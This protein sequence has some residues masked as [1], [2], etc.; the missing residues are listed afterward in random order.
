MR[1]SEPKKPKGMKVWPMVVMIVFMMMVAELM[2]RLPGEDVPE[3]G[4]GAGSS[5]DSSSTVEREPESLLVSESEPIEDDLVVDDVPRFTLEGPY[6]TLPALQGSLFAIGGDPDSLI[7]RTEQ[8]FAL[9]NWRS[10]VVIREIERPAGNANVYTDDKGQITA[11]YGWGLIIWNNRLE[12]VCRRDF[13]QS[14]T[15]PHDVLY[16]GGGLGYWYASPDG[17]YLTRCDDEGIKLFN[18]ET[19][20]MRL[21]PDTGR[22]VLRPEHPDGAQYKYARFVLNGSKLLCWHIGWEWTE[23]YMIYDLETGQQSYHPHGSEES[24]YVGIGDAGVYLT[25]Y[26]RYDDKSPHGYVYIDFKTGE[27]RAAPELEAIW[28]YFEFSYA[29]SMG[30]YVV[31]LALQHVA[32]A[33][34]ALAADTLVRKI[35]VLD[36][37]T[38]EVYDTGCTVTTQGGA[39]CDAMALPDGRVYLQVTGTEE[40]QG[41]ITG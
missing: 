9:V 25:G 10:G 12:E 23:G 3:G 7:L 37:H 29:Q 34:E 1:G 16:S 18:L 38:G 26:R 30:R 24:M 14:V 39:Y 5:A 19:G 41:F 2:A 27:S 17:L 40:T 11:L 31:K 32:D 33:G 13:P 21:L 35:T 22:V 28:N 4:E 20:E 8:G 6:E 15:A 36:S